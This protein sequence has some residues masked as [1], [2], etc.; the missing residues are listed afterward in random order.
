MPWHPERRTRLVYGARRR[1]RLPRPPRIHHLSVQE[2]EPPVC[3]PVGKGGWVVGHSCGRQR[4]IKSDLV[5]F[6]TRTPHGKGLRLATDATS[7]TTKESAHALV[8]ARR[9]TLHGLRWVLD[10]V[11]QHC[12]NTVWLWLGSGRVTT[13]SQHCVAWIRYTAEQAALLFERFDTNSDGQPSTH[14]LT[15]TTCA[16]R[17]VVA[18]EHTRTCTRTRATV[19]AVVV[20][21]ALV[22]AARPTAKPSDSTA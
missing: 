14:T 16:P 15:G 17:G 10:Q 8:V 1:Q 13:L 18:R 6:S 20:G 7:D 4:S 5:R 2:I 19:A 11:S 9:L 22:G 12:H 3:M 21:F